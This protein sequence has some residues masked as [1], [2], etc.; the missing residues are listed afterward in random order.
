MK[1]WERLVITAACCLSTV[2]SAAIIAVA[3]ALPRYQVS[4]KDPDSFT[5]NDRFLSDIYECTMVDK[6]F[7]CLKINPA[8]SV[9]LELRSGKAERE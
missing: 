5:I 9:R 8:G 7:A 4:H 2:L 1:P 6:V 3:I